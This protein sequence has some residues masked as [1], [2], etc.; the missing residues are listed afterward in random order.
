[1]RRALITLLSLLLALSVSGCKLKKAIEQA[2]VSAELASKGTTDLL[3][4]AAKD[5]YT[6]PEDGRL[7]EAQIQMYLKVRDREKAIAK[8]ARQELQQH[9]AKANAAGEKS[10]TGVMEGFKSLGSMA[11]FATADI[12]AAQELGFNTQEYTWVKGQILASSASVVTQKLQESMK[13][14]MT[15]IEKQLKADPN[16][17]KLLEQ[18]KAAPDQAE[19][20]SVEPED[21][22][23]V[24]N[25]QLLSKYENALNAFTTE[26]SKWEEKEGD[27]AKSMTEWQKA[28]DKAIAEAEKPVAQP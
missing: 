5:K 12:R 14:Q 9:A 25:R 13:A 3:K 7:T 4:Q 16:T 11:D 20:A 2:S 8:V 1:M 27:A 6:A 24:Y 15:A 19:V 26:M 17:A 18:A 10:L 21:P 22:A 23:L 28:T